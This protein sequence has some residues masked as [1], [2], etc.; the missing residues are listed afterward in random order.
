MQRL[1]RHP[2][3]GGHLGDLRSRQH[4]PN[5][6]QPLLDNRQDNQCQSRPPCLE[7]ARGASRHRM[8]EHD[9]RQASADTRLFERLAIRPENGP[10][11][12]FVHDDDLT[13]Y[14]RKGGDENA[15]F[16][17]CGTV[18]VL[19]GINGEDYIK[20]ERDRHENGEGSAWHA[21]VAKHSLEVAIKAMAALEAHVPSEETIADRIGDLA[22]RATELLTDPTQ[23]GVPSS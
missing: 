15:R 16:T 2:N 10:T 1:T 18:V 3:L 6:V 14:L 4:G 9:R 13:M 11:I 20:V 19:M 23:A 5:R 7:D 22:R 12:P 21:E 8:A 17:E